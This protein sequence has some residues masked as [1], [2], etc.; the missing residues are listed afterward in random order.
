MRARL[1]V[2]LEAGLVPPEERHK[3]DLSTFQIVELTGADRDGWEAAKAAVE[4]PHG[5]RPLAWFRD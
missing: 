1:V 3:T 2:A 5:S 4:I